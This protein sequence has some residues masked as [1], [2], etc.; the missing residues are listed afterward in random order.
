MTFVCNVVL[1][2]AVLFA[3]RQPESLLD[4]LP[5]HRLALVPFHFDYF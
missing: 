3:I 1:N 4:V 2:F 5:D